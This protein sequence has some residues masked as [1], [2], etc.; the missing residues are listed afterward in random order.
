MTTQPGTNWTL[1][2][3][4]A[5]CT[6]WVQV[7]H[8]SITGNEMQL[9]E[10]WS[11]IHTNYLEKMGGQ[12]TKE[13]MSSRWKLL[14]QSFSTWRDALAQ[15][16][17]N[18]RSGENLTDQELQAQ[19]W[20][21]AKTKSKNKTFT[22][23]ECWNIVKDCPKF[24]VVHVGPEVF[25]NSTPLHS[26]PEHASHDHDEDDEE[27]PETPPVEQASGSTRYPIRP[28][29]KKA[30][31]RKGNASKNDYAKYME[32]LAR[33]GE[34]NLAREM[35][36][37]EADKA[38]EDAKAAA[39]ERKFEADERERELLRQEREHRREER[40]AERDR[41]IMK[42]P[43][44]GKSPDSKY[45]WKS[46]KADVLRRRRAREARARGDGPST[47]REDYPSMTR[48]DHPSTTNWLGDGYHPFTNP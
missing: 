38:R 25:M 24:R 8:D 2:E 3:D 40:M 37:F 19:A 41:D 46:E 21:G 33:Q 11:L 34:L 47:T 4:V 29:G 42:E 6:S 9:R 22:R 32:D 30:S 26:T 1:L 28:Q 39:F 18:L 15:A 14:S 16:S 20:Y 48:E 36:K 23:F 17:G 35:A 5:L 27:V 43:L 12:R 31:K 44:E 13:S 7:T 45:F 10:M